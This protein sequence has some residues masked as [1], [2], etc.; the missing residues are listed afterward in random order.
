MRSELDHPA[1]AAHRVWRVVES[2]WRERRLARWDVRPGSYRRE[3]FFVWKVLGISLKEKW[4]RKF[5]SLNEFFLPRPIHWRRFVEMC[6]MCSFSS[7]LRLYRN[8][9]DVFLPGKQAACRSLSSACTYVCQWIL[10]FESL[11][12]C[13]LCTNNSAI[14]AKERNADKYLSCCLSLDTKSPKLSVLSLGNVDQTK[15]DGKFDNVVETSW[16]SCI[17]LNS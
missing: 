3:K 8:L 11:C 2:S 9:S 17:E 16:F 5:G 7:R 1:G 4:W 13:S 14:S 6:L 15:T 12:L 10:P